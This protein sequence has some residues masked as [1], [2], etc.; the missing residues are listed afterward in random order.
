MY[1]QEKMAELLPKCKWTNMADLDAVLKLYKKT[2]TAILGGIKQ[3][4]FD[5]MQLDAGD[6]WRSPQ[7]LARALG[8][9]ESLEVLSLDGI[10]LRAL[11]KLGAHVH[12]HDL[13]VLLD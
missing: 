4:D 3:L 2:A 7:R 13:Q 11:L 6:E 10:E 12:I 1:K 5:G 9:C 8:Y